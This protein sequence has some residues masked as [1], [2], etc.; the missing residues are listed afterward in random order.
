MKH[1]NK[2]CLQDGIP[3]RVKACCEGT[4]GLSSDKEQKMIDNYE[5]IQSSPPQTSSEMP[6][7]FS[8]AAN[9]I[10]SAVGHALEGFPATP[11]AERERRLSICRA[12][13]EFE[14]NAARCKQCGCFMNTKAGWLDAR[15]PLNKWVVATPVENKEGLPPKDDNPLD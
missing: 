3:T 13:P 9:F 8:Q 2:I 6:G 12:C 4:S 5:K 11:E 10:T 1:N 7:L 15:C 14:P